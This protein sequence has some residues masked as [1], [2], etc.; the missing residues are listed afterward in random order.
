MTEAGFDVS[1]PIV[2]GHIKGVPATALTASAALRA[3][4]L[5]L[6]PMTKTML[7]LAA[8]LMMYPKLLVILLFNWT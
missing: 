5:K 7:S 6:L 3:L 8:T 4:P 2:M 1:A